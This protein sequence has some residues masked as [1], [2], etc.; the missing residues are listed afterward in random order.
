MAEYTETEIRV[1]IAAIDAQIDALV[2]AGV[3]N[4]TIGGNAGHSVEADKSM[5]SL[6]KLRK[7]WED[8]LADIDTPGFTQTGVDLSDA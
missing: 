6:L 4:N 2:A 8:K 1:K 3:P 7:M 5:A